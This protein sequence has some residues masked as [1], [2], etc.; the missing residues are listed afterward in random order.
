MDHSPAGMGQTALRVNTAPGYQCMHK[1]TRQALESEDSGNLQVAQWRSPLFDYEKFQKSNTSIL[2][3]KG[4]I[5]TRNEAFA[6]YL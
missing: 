2:E 6:D 1:E 5:F 3:F 4:Y